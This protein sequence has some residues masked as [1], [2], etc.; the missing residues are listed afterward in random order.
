MQ[1]KITRDGFAPVGNSPNPPITPHVYEST[2]SF[3]KLF[4]AAFDEHTEGNIIE[5]VQVRSAN[6][7]DIVSRICERL[8]AKNFLDVNDIIFILQMDEGNTVH[9]LVPDAYDNLYDAQPTKEQQ[10]SSPNKASG[11]FDYA[12]KLAMQEIE[13]QTLR[14][15]WNVYKRDMQLAMKRMAEAEDFIEGLR[16]DIAR[17]HSIVIAKLSQLNKKPWWKVW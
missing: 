11:E 5:D 15:E 8:T 6:T 7:A 2:E 12:H 13:K 4:E 3:E 14:D 10:V 17:T 16:S 1:L 9:E